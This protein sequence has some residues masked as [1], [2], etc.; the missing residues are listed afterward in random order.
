[1]L[2]SYAAWDFDAATSSRKDHSNPLREKRSRTSPL[3]EPASHR[4]VKLKCESLL[5]IVIMRV[6]ARVCQELMPENSFEEP[7]RRQARGEM[8][9]AQLLRAAG[10]IFAEVGYEG[11]TTNAIAARAGASPGTLYQFFPNKQAI[12]EAL[13]REYA[14]RNQAAHESASDPNMLRMPLCELIDRMVDPFLEFRRSAPGFEALFTGSVVSRELAERIQVLHGHLKQRTARLIQMRAPHLS[15][16]AV[17]TAAETTLQIVKGL[18]PLALNGSP[19]QR[20]AGARELKLVLERYLAPLDRVQGAPT[21]ALR[22]LQSDQKG[23][24]KRESNRR[25]E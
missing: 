18:L 7:R 14:A 23:S 24:R 16:E 4:S 9:I 5:V 2:R 8:R 19:K 20:E 3:F 12:A 21:E 15:A 1:M 11:A 25:K 10:E 6:N 13:A 22:A 17:E